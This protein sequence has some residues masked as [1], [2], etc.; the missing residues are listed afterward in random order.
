MREQNIWEIGTLSKKV[1]DL[2]NLDLEEQVILIGDQNIEHM[3]NQHPED[4]EKYG[5]KI[6]E[7]ISSPT[8]VCK[9]PKKPSIEFVKFFKL[10]NKHVLVAVRA[11]GKGILFARTLFVMSDEKVEKYKSK[12]AFK[13][14]KT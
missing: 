8:Y 13:K 9:H 5:D 12:N 2:I 3:K 11:T 6:S 10:D 4:F 1:I 14:F 7:I